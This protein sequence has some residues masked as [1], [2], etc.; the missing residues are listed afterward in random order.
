MKYQFI[1]QVL[2]ARVAGTGI[3]LVDNIKNERTGKISYKEYKIWGIKSFINE[4][5]HDIYTALVLKL[6]ENESKFNSD[7]LIE[8]LLSLCEKFNCSTI[9]FEKNIESLKIFPEIWETMDNEQQASFYLNSFFEI[10]ENSRINNYKIAL[11]FS[12]LLCVLFGKNGIRENEQELRDIDFLKKDFGFVFRAREYVKAFSYSLSNGHYKNLLKRLNQA[13]YQEYLDTFIFNVIIE[14]SMSR[15]DCEPEIEFNGNIFETFE[16][17]RNGTDREKLKAIE[18]II[19][20]KYF[21]AIDEL[22]YYLNNINPD[23]MNA[24]LDAIIYLKEIIE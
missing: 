23:V 15:E 13:L 4:F 8:P 11:S 1:H 20:N 16:L 10:L 19:E 17:L 2:Y 9:D 3:H 18:I 7:D 14:K 5:V 24:A 22:E 12:Q 21:E 6:P